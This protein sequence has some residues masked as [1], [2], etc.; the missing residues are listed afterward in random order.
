MKPAGGIKG[1]RPDDKLKDLA[2]MLREG[3]FA[4]ENEEW[5][6]FE[7]AFAPQPPDTDAGRGYRQGTAWRHTEAELKALDSVDPTKRVRQGLTSPDPVNYPGTEVH[8]K[9]FLQT[10][11]ASH[12]EAASKR[13]LEYR[14][15]AKKAERRYEDLSVKVNM[16]GTSYEDPDPPGA[17]QGTELKDWLDA[18]REA[19]NY[20]EMRLLSFER[21]LSLFLYE[22]MCASDDEQKKLLWDRRDQAGQLADTFGPDPHT[23]T[24][25]FDFAMKQVEAQEYAFSGLLL[26]LWEGIIQSPDI[27]PK[28]TEEDKQ[29]AKRYMRKLKLAEA[30]IIDMTAA[31]TNDKNTQVMKVRAENNLQ[32][33]ERAYKEMLL[34][35]F[36]FIEHC[37]D[38]ADKL[39]SFEH[40][41]GNDNLKEYVALLVQGFLQ[42]GTRLFG[43]YQNFTLEGPSGVGKTTWA[44]RIAGV[45]GAMGMLLYSDVVQTDATAFIAEFL[46]QSGPLTKQKILGSLEKVLFI[47]EAYAVAGNYD[48]RH[49]GWTSKDAIDM[50]VAQL[51]QIR[52]LQVM[53]AA[54][55]QKDMSRQFF[56]VNS[57]MIRRF[58][59]RF[60]LPK[61]THEALSDIMLKMLGDRKDVWHWSTS[62]CFEIALDKLEQLARKQA[63]VTADPAKAY[64]GLTSAD[65]EEKEA[66]DAEKMAETP[67]GAA[68]DDLTGKQAGSIEMVVNLMSMHTGN[69]EVRPPDR[70]ALE[71][72]AVDNAALDKLLDPRRVEYRGPALPSGA[73]GAGKAE[74]QRTGGYYYTYTPDMVTVIAGVITDATVAG[75]L[76][77]D[78][79]KTARIFK[80]VYDAVY[81]APLECYRAFRDDKTRNGYYLTISSK[82]K[83]DDASRTPEPALQDEQTPKFKREQFRN[84]YLQTD[85]NS[86]EEELDRAARTEVPAPTGPTRRATIAV[87]HVR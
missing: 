3:K 87:T 68:L 42:K 50:I 71:A 2:K 81:T 30:Q 46:N 13:Y 22:I 5:K 24:R 35:P 78:G 57:G 6:R 28:P 10:V 56:G 9:P 40:L 36:D 79:S 62:V 43:Q 85:K 58:A 4:T 61:Y 26:H 21:L 47:D 8:G 59:T 84:Y 49:G 66:E 29:V 60:I 38:A 7:E 44:T 63:K 54:G 20:N 48:E 65:R 72:D 67:A 33:T 27:V 69:V 12:K 52:G 53:I 15:R 64:G 31:L 17:N 34:R 25:R 80:D 74:Y 37:N 55:Y 14:A 45:Y 75:D 73:K 23:V 1:K 18:K 82:Y 16:T 70:R 39:A 86:S 83:K 51:D 77:Q 76:R 41:G 19:T 11:F 32:D